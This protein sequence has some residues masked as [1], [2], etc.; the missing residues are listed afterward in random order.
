MET[1][2]I[3]P[4]IIIEILLPKQIFYVIAEYYYLSTFFVLQTDNFEEFQNSF[5]VYKF[6]IPAPPYWCVRTVSKNSI[7]S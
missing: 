1:M 5:Q 4:A 3:Y 2:D 7:G 6:H